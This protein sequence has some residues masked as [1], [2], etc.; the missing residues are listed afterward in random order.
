MKNVKRKDFLVEIGR[1][2]NRF[3]SILFIVA[4][5]VAF[6]S[7]IRAS[8]PDMELSADR[9]YDETHLMDIRI[10]GTLGLTEDDLTAVRGMEEVRLAE[11]AYETDV[12]CK[13]ED[14]EQVMRIFSLT[15]DVN[16][17]TVQ[18]GRLPQKQGECLIDRGKITSGVYQIGDQVQVYSG[19]DDA[20]EDTL[21]TN[22][23]TVVG[24]GT[25]SRYLSLERG[26]TGIGDG[27][28]DCFMVVTPDNFALEVYTDIYLLTEKGESLT[29]YSEEYD[30]YI[31]QITTS[32]EDHLSEERSR[33]RYEEVVGEADEKLNDARVELAEKK[34]EADDKLADAARQIAEADEKI[35]DGHKDVE[36]GQ[37][38][39]NQ[40]KADLAQ[41]EVDLADGKKKLA[42]KVKELEDAK[43]TLAEKEQELADAK[44]TLA[45]KEQEL[46]DGKKEVEEKEPK[47]E[48]ARNKFEE[49]TEGAISDL[50]YGWQDYEYGLEEY[51]Q[52]YDT[53]KE[54]KE[55]LKE[56]KNQ[57]RRDMADANK[58]ASTLQEKE[59]NRLYDQAVEAQFH[60]QQEQLNAAEQ[61]LKAVKKQLS[62]AK[63]KLK[64]GQEK[65]D[66]AQTKI[67]DGEQE[68]ADAKQKIIDGDQ[69]VAEAHR[70]ITDAEIKIAEA[71]QDIAEGDAK[72]ADAYEEIRDGESKIPKAKADIKKGETDIADARKK[73]EEGEADLADAK[74][75]YSDSKAEA[76]QKIA[77]AQKKI[78]DAQKD[79]NEIEVGEWFVLDRNK[80]QTYVE[81]G[82]DAE[83]IGAIG[84]VFPFIF[85]L[86]AALVSLTTMTRMVEEQRLQ[87][88]T[89]KALGYGKWSIASKYILYAFWATLAG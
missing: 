56:A 71:H 65:I 32:I 70:D 21:K 24:I 15:R 82:N 72:I 33:I 5:G 27:S 73:L 6:F 57:H 47:L 30:D 1:S 87:I 40:G 75:K 16:Q 37:K 74:I 66:K 7:G 80:I 46:A 26:T 88:G 48:D 59:A 14:R 77:D 12:L 83:R 17:F 85:F 49:K 54:Q 2:M 86:V 10:A 38:D 29:A 43:V 64:L 39:L 18:E 45:E 4:L 25:S 79:I 28:L 52:A 68:L 53:L 50:E 62:S 63:H 3:L 35:A 51:E 20:W 22:I 23:Y 41:A 84:K 44:V 61:Q 11:G 42:E 9:Y 19:T 8:R 13:M 58:E 78:D 67:I 81:Y 31:E 36:Q 34:Q 55:N 76:E 60:M 89:L 69:K